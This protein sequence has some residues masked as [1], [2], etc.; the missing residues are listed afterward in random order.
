[1]TGVINE[2]EADGGVVVQTRMVVEYGVELDGVWLPLPML[3]RLAAHGPW[4]RPFI[5]AAA[6]QERV[7]LAHSLAERHN[8]T[9]LHR[10]VG[11]SGFLS[12]IPFEPTVPFPAAS[13]TVTQGRPAKCASPVPVMGR[14]PCLAGRRR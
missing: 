4:D 7:L 12:A 5:E 9:G 10:G 13:G 3:R 11:L 14:A 2:L 1:M 6:D 8:Q